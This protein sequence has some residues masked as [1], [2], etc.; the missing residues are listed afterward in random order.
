M[1]QR[2]PRI[3]PVQIRTTPEIADLW[4]RTLLLVSQE[5]LRANGGELLRRMLLRERRRISNEYGAGWIERVEAAY[6]RP[7]RARAATQAPPPKPSTL[8]D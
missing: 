8:V 3:Q 6:Y 4:S 2:G 5:R 7:K 1:Y